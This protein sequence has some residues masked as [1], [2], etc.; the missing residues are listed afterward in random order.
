MSIEF[1]IEEKLQ[2]SADV[3][4]RYIDL[5]MLKPNNEDATIEWGSLWSPC[6]TADAW[7]DH[8]LDRRPNRSSL[9]PTD[10]EYAMRLFGK[11]CVARNVWDPEW[12]KLSV[13]LDLDGASGS[14]PWESL[15][16]DRVYFI[17]PEP[18]DATI[19]NLMG[20]RVAVAAVGFSPSQVLTTGSTGPYKP[21]YRKVG[22]E[23]HRV[24]DS[25]GNS[26]LKVNTE[27]AAAY[28][29]PTTGAGSRVFLLDT[30]ASYAEAEEA[31]VDLGN[32]VREFRRDPFADD[33]A[34][35]LT[36]VDD[37]EVNEV[38]TGF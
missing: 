29:D 18:E 23:W 8:A 31:A 38:V 2:R 12:S 6:V 25:M 28:H 26:K 30:W 15:T 36:I 7:M 16:A 11:F 3:I 37:P 34:P 1:S 33:L 32:A 22:D 13:T 14:K 20:G 5:R 17:C 19:H 21:I 24:T 10:R 4:G 27:C 9:N 35:E